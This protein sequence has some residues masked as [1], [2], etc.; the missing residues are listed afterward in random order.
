[1]LKYILLLLIFLVCLVILKL[2][3]NRNISEGFEAQDRDINSYQSPQ[4]FDKFYASIYD[5][6]VLDDFKNAYELSNIMEIIDVNNKKILDIGSGTGHHVNILNKH[7]G[8]VCDGIDISQDMVLKAQENYPAIKDRFKLGDV[9]NNMT[10]QKNSYNI[11]TVFY[12][13]IYY[14]KNKRQ[15]FHNCYDWLEDGGYLVIHLVNKDKFNP[16]ISAGDHFKFVSPQNYSK[17]RITNSIIDF[18]GF[19]YISDFKLNNNNGNFEEWFKF[20][21]PRKDV[22]LNQH[23]LYMDNQKDILSMA[24]DVGFKYIKNIDLGKCSYDN[25][26]IYILQR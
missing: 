5:L 18:K 20:K 1:M 9:L 6:L 19:K 4:L 3:C 12:F 8:V 13:T 10:V 14:L 24:R 21:S 26:F 7:N 23:M 22:R 15:F 2:L 16:I 17:K 25:Q 11:I